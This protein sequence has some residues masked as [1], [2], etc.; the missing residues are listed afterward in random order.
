[1]N[2]HLFPPIQRAAYSDRM[3]WILAECSEIAYERK[4]EIPSRLIKYGLRLKNMYFCDQN[5]N[6]GYLAE[7]ERYAVLVFKGTVPSESKTIQTDLDFKFVKQKYG[8]FHQGFLDTYKEMEKDIE[9]DLKNIKVPLFVAGHSLGGALGLTATI[10]LRE[11]DKLAACYTY[12]C[13]MIGNAQFADKL[14]KVPVYRCVHHADMVP[15]IP[16]WT[17]GYRQYGDIRYLTDDGKVCGGS[18]AVFRR[19][20]AS[21]NP[22]NFFRW[23]SDHGIEAY[24]RTLHEFAEERNP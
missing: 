4:Y 24:I 19:L 12:G 23:V 20:G 22:L 16:L 5:E 13:P 11:Q 10:F 9:R 17:M 15:S 6:S 14:F 1:M 3:A 2:S 21:L 7:E 18:E 8:E